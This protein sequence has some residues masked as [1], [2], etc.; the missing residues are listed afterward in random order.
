MQRRPGGNK[1]SRMQPGRERLRPRG[2]GG[3]EAALTS[4][5]P[6]RSPSRFL[7]SPEIKLRFVTV[8]GS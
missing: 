4:P 1:R 7:P 5:L 8:L 2:P 3:T 6:M